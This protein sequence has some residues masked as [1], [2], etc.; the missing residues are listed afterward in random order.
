MTIPTRLFIVLSFALALAIWSNGAH[1]AFAADGPQADIR[2]IADA[3]QKDDMK[4]AQAMAK[5]LAGTAEMED[6]M[7]MFA[8]RTS[9]GEGVG[10][11]AGAIKPDGIEAKLMN[12]LKRPMSPEQLKSEAAAIER[13]AYISAAIGEI[14]VHKAPK[15]K[16]G[17]MDPEKWK[18]WSADLS[19]AALELAKEAKGSDGKKIMAA[20]IKLDNVCKNCHGVYKP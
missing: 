1:T 17:E 3:L 7:H 9:K 8:L 6:I 19:K 16:T 20:A 12:M 2:K 14:V 18:Q 11:K 4:A 13:M 15:E 10:P 5:T